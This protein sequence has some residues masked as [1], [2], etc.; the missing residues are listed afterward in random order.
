M[1]TRVA[2]VENGFWTITSNRRELC[3]TER[4]RLIEY[5]QEI[6]FPYRIIDGH[7]RVPQ[8]VPWDDIFER[9][10]HFYDGEARATPF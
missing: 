3:A 5:F 9:L 6:R 4:D 7:I 10:E 1:K 2:R 8:T